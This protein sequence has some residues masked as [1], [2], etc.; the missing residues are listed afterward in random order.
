[1]HEVAAVQIE[2]WDCVADLLGRIGRDDTDQR[3]HLLQRLPG[4]GREAG[5]VVVD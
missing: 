1:M 2:G 4:R 5:N 3:S